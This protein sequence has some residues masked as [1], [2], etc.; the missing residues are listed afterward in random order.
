MDI[1]IRDAKD[2]TPLHWACFTRSEMALNYIL[3]LKPNMEAKDKFGYT[4][5]HIASQCVE[6]LE[7]LGLLSS[8]TPSKTAFEGLIRGLSTNT[9]LKLADFELSQV[10]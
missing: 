10:E 6:K 3:S 7:S 2:S 4:P 5:L 8:N 9:H 1:D